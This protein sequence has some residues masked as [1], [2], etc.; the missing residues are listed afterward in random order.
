MEMRCI[1][2]V[3]KFEEANGSFSKV[4]EELSHE[5]INMSMKQLF[6]K[7]THIIDD[8]VKA[9]SFF[10]MEVNIVMDKDNQF[11]DTHDF[12]SIKT[13][14][15]GTVSDIVKASPTN[16]DNNMLIDAFIGC[17][18][19][20]FRLDTKYVSNLVNLKLDTIEEGWK[21]VE[22]VREKLEN[23]NTLTLKDIYEK[24]KS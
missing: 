10:I 17:E 5:D 14:S 20:I 23:M 8:D 21:W 6:E 4:L 2:K 19:D 11:N 3:Y 18:P 13:S 9:N 15:I 24:L 12:Y 16:L 7:V 1:I 22:D